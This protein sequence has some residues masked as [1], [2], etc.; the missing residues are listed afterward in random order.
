[1]CQGKGAV[2]SK[3]KSVLAPFSQWVA[4]IK[5]TQEAC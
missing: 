2:L 4:D 1:M 3:E 5:E